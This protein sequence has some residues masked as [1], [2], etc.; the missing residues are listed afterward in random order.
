MKN[1]YWI[2]LILAL[3]GALLLSACAP[4]ETATP[5]TPGAVSTATQPASPTSAPTPVATNLPTSAPTSQ[6]PTV[7]PTENIPATGAGTPAAGT[8]ATP[9][10][11]I[12]A[13][14]N[15]VVT[16]ADDG[17][18]INMQ[19]GQRFL[20]QLGEEYDWNVIPADQSVLSRVIGITVIRGAQGIYEAR[21]AGT[22]TLTASGMPTC[23]NGKPGCTPSTTERQ[24]K[25]TVVV[26]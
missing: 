9:A 13:G 15:T 6:P 12:T 16:L 1:R 2:P 24:F 8:P 26:K 17:A 20:L 19:V 10:G 21:Q 11:P 4:A 14:D 7:A 25:I 3:G 23:L 5:I 18:T 22:T